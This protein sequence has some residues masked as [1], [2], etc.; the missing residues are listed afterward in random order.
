MEKKITQ[1]VQS[2]ESAKKLTT[3]LM[4][5]VVDK[6][7]YHTKPLLIYLLPPHWHHMNHFFQCVTIA[8]HIDAG[9]VVCTLIEKGKLVN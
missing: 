7:T 2:S 8:W 4:N 9:S 1:E 3:V 6:S 5:M